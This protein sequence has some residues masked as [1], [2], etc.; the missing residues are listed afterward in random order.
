MLMGLQRDEVRQVAAEWLATLNADTRDVAVTNVLN[1][2]LGYPHKKWEAWPK[3]IS[4]EHATI[5]EILG[6][7]LGRAL[8]TRPNGYFDRLR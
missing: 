4:A 2:L 5:N 7:W 1:N 6:R 8:D 3:Y